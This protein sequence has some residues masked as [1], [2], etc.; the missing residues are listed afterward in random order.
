MTMDAPGRLVAARGVSGL[1][2]G[3]I[4]PMWPNGLGLMFYNGANGLIYY[5]SQAARLFVSN[6]GIIATITISGYLFP[7]QTAY[8]VAG[9]V[10]IRGTTWLTKKVDEE[11]HVHIADVMDKVIDMVPSSVAVGYMDL[12]L[13]IGRPQRSVSTAIENTPQLNWVNDSLATE[14]VS[15]LLEETIF[16]VGVQEGL[17]L[18]LT[19]VGIPRPAAGFLAGAISASLFAGAHNVDPGSRQYRDTLVS[20]IGFGLMMYLHG[21]PAAV[22]AHSANNAGVRLERALR[23]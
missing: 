21:L 18:G 6:A 7:R 3:G 16:R 13:A 23:L 1:D 19:A 11:H 15:P 17:S 14:L 5:S 8:G 12:S 2:S 10:A 22:V 4:L 20:G 9:A